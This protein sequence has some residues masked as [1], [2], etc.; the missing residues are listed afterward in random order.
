[1]VCEHA[2]IIHGS[3]MLS[4]FDCALTGKKCTWFESA[5]CK[6]YKEKNIVDIVV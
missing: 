6:D 5:S 2:K 3:P 4:D 1:M